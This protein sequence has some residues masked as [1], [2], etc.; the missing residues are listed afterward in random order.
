MAG[1]ANPGEDET[2][3]VDRGGNLKIKPVTFRCGLCRF[4]VVH[5]KAGLTTDVADDGARQNNVGA[6]RRWVAWGW[7]PLNRINQPFIQVGVAS[8]PVSPCAGPGPRDAAGKVFL[9]FPSAC[10]RPRPSRAATLGA[11]PWS[12]VVPTASRIARQSRSSTTSG[13]VHRQSAVTAA[14]G[15][16]P[17]RPSFL[18]TR[19]AA[20]AMQR[21]ESSRQLSSITRSRIA[22]T[23]VCSGIR[24]TGSRCASGTTTRSS[25]PKS[26]ARGGGVKSLPANRSRPAA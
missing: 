20:C 2:V 22:A 13:A 6:S 11:R 17:G 23:R 12:E 25:R 21:A 1:R 7:R 24:R 15:R 10:Q 19:S 16:K 26:A 5:L 18:A 9:G 14:D 8:A 4:R 3:G